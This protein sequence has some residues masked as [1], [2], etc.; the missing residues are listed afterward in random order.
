VSCRLTVVDSVGVLGSGV[1]E[2]MARYWC[3]S[4]AVLDAVDE[5]LVLVATAREKYR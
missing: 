3:N 2:L 5:R 4:A 1:A